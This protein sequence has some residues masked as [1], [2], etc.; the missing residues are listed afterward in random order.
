MSA[1]SIFPCPFCAS[2]QVTSI[3]IDIDRWS[4]VCNSCGG[5]GPT[6]ESLAEA[7]EAWNGRQVLA[8][9]LGLIRSA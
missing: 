9:N 4:I 5:V 3:E 8:Q 1:N 2:D 6:T 7:K